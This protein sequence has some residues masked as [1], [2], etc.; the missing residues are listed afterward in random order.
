MLVTVSWMPNKLPS[1]VLLTL[2]IIPDQGLFAGAATNR[3]NKEHWQAQYVEQR[4]AISNIV[5]CI[6]YAFGLPQF[7][8]LWNQHGLIINPMPNALFEELYRDDVTYQDK[9][10]TIEKMT[11]QMKVSWDPLTG[12]NIYTNRQEHYQYLTQKCNDQA[13]DNTMV[14]QSLP[15]AEVVPNLECA[16]REWKQK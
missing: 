1:P 11:T 3:Q 15:S 5:E 6:Y 7:A 13:T 12:F 10:E 14:Q 4:K 8:D 9:Q 16:C 2:A